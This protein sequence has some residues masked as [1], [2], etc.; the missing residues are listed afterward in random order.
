VPKPPTLLLCCLAAAC[1]AQTK[2]TTNTEAA[3]TAAALDQE[4]A[5]ACPWPPDADRYGSTTLTA[6][7]L[8]AAAPDLGILRDMPNGC[9]ILTFAVDDN[10]II[11]SSTVVTQNPAGYAR[12]AKDVLSWND[13]AT[14]DPTLPQFMVRVAARP[15]PN[16]DALVALAFKDNT[17]NF[18]VPASASQ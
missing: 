11:D 6:R 15:L 1:A 18:V 7:H 3:A 14:G 9:A 17:L 10:G 16:G 12:I 4:A 13:Y 5:A 8:H 2:P